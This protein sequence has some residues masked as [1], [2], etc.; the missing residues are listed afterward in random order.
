MSGNLNFT[1]NT[2]CINEWMLSHEKVTD[3]LS[4]CKCLVFFSFSFAKILSYVKFEV[5]EGPCYTAF[6]TSACYML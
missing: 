3:I 6:G 1:I 5:E 2:Y 4:V